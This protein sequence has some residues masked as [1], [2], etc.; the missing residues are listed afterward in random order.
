MCGRFANAIP[1]KVIAE[2][3]SLSDLPL[4]P[5]HWN[6]A[7]SQTVPILRQEHM[8]NRELIMARWGLVPHW[9]KDIAIGNRLINARSET[10][11]EKPAFR[12]SIRSRRCIIPANGFFEWAKKSKSKMPYYFSMKDDTPMAMAG[13]WDSW[14]TPEGINLESFSI[15]T[16]GANSLLAPIHDRMPVV[17]NPADFDLWLDRSM[18]IPEKLIPILQPYPSELLQSWPVL[19]TVN[20]PRN[21][22]KEC[23]LPV[24]EH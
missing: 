17:C 14:E 1:P 2:Y 21:D 5:P 18:N 11:H 6:I 3:F 9:A 7:P 12:K 19:T 24:Q 20:N 15:L 10:A 16:T 22:T 4:F 23:I 13:I 8:G